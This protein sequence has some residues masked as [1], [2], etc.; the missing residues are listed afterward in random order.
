MLAFALLGIA[1]LALA[2]FVL[3][4][5]RAVA[6]A[7]GRLASLHSRPSYHGLFA[8]L[9][10]LLAGYGTYLVASAVSTS[11]VGAQMRDALAGLAPEVT[12]LKAETVLTDA[13]ALATGGIASVDDTLC[14]NLL[15]VI[16][17]LS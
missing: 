15:S 2:A 8:L 17:G 7:G 6:A 11:V 16:A 12:G 1:G 3:A 10:V 5:S 14:L 13:R 4:R 9:C